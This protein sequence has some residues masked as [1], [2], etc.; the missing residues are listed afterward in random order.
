MNSSLVG[1][2]HSKSVPLYVLRVSTHSAGASHTGAQN[3]LI[4]RREA[5]VARG[6]PRATTA[7]IAS[8]SGARLVDLD[9]R[10]FIDFAA[11]IGVANAGHSPPQVVDAIIEQARRLLHAGIHVA[12][13]ESYVALCE[14]LVDL[15]PHGNKTK[16]MLVNSGAEAVENAIKIARQATGRPAVVCFSGAFHGRTLLGMTL[17]SKTAYKSGCGPFAPEIYRLPFPD[18]LRH[19][20]GQDEATFVAAALSN[21]EEALATHVA[22]I[23]VAAILIEPVLGEGGFIPAPKAYLEGLR[24]FA[25]KH[26]IMLVFDEVQ[27]GFG[28]TGHWGAYQHYGVTPDLSTW[29]K[30]MG[31]GL[32]IAAV[33]G[34]AEVMDAAKPG[35]IGG[36]YGGNPVACAAALANIKLIEDL[37]LL[38]RA[39]QIGDRVRQR[40]GALQK[41]CTAIADVRGLGAMMAVELCVG[42]DPHRPD[43]KLVADVLAASFDRGLIALSSGVHHNAIR[44]LSPLVISDEDLDQGLTIIEEELLRRAS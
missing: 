12:T 24:Q 25:T 3:A 8:G 36:T 35:T 17:T 22:A 11:G 26:G 16:A 37:G 18:R 30:A 21:L 14:R 6:V 44:V 15:L 41:R 19:G 29:A 38:P 20:Q 23:D 1:Q 34:R 28:R 10:S 31:G 32:P 9:G 27:T 5:V 4:T 7:A 39:Q 43:A 2:I 13:Y 42:G 40:F 33:V